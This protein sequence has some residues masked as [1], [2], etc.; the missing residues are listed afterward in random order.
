MM[1]RDGAHFSVSEKRAFFRENFT[2]QFLRIQQPFV[3]EHPDG[4]SR[5]GFAQTV[6]D[7]PAVKRIRLPRSL[8]EHR[9]VSDAQEVMSKAFT[10]VLHFV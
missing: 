1:H 10:V 9:A 3:N 6:C 7:V 8:A 5:K 2:Y 4:S